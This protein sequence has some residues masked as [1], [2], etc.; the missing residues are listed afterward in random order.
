MTVVS[1]H[2]AKDEHTTIPQQGWA[3]RVLIFRAAAQQQHET[4]G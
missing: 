2:V 1:R 4:R 3:G